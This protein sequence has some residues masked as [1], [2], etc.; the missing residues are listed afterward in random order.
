MP[1]FW[2]LIESVTC[3]NHEV[4][5]RIARNRRKKFVPGPGAKFRR[6]WPVKSL[7]GGAI[8]YL[9]LFFQVVDHR[10]F[11]VVEAF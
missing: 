9:V 11:H 7:A 2:P 8:P 10:E 4:M 6:R 1:G 5:N 3:I